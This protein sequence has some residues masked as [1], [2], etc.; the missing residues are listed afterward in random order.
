MAQN[1]PESEMGGG[2]SGRGAESRWRAPRVHQDGLVP[3]RG[4]PALEPCQAMK[5][6]T[7]SRGHLG[8]SAS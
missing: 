6:W 5:Y 2:G 8:T 1:L 3:S 7:S 4:A